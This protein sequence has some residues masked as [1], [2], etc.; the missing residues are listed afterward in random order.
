[1]EFLRIFQELN[2]FLEFFFGF[3]GA[4]YIF[5]GGFFLLRGKKA[6]AGFAEA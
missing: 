6:R 3:V 2:N 1:L 4:G 5:E